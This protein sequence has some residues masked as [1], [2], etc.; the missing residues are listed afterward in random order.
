MRE[1]L[2]KT[3][4]KAYGVTMFAAFFGGL[5]PLIPFVIALA[6]GG[7]TGERIATFL[8]NSFYPWI[9]AMASVSVIIGLIAMYVGK[10]SALSTKS[11]KKSK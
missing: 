3:L 11:F 2:Y 9:I 6:I 4:N 5:L 8:Y 1:K 10:H 7:S